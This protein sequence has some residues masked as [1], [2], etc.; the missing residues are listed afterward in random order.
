M[1]QTQRTQIYL[2]KDL[3]NEIDK[4]RNQNGESLAE[5]LRK[6]AEERVKKD[7]EKDIN[8][9]KLAEK[10]TSGVKQSG[11][12]DMDVIKWQRDMRKDRK[13]S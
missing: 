2:P 13:V 12:K 11:W 7:K 8:F 10:I 1:I 3:R 6:A 4:A 5:Y 9:K